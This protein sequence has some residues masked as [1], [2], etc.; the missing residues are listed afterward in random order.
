MNDTI[1]FLKPI[2]QER[3]WGGNRLS[4]IFNYNLTSDKIGECWGISAH[5]NGDCEITNP[6]YSGYTL[7][8]LF[9][10]RKDLFN[11]DKSKEFPLLI[12]ILDAN[13]SLSVQVHPDDEYALKYENDLGKNECWY[14]LDA[15]EDAFVIYGHIAKTEVEFRLMIEQGKWDDLLIKKHVKKGDFINV[16]AGTIHALGAGLLILETQQS[17]D[18]T[19]RLYDYDRTDDKGNKRQ[20]HI[21]ESIR[22]STIPHVEKQVHFDVHTMGDN[23][24][25]KLVK[26]EFFIVEKWDIKTSVT[27]NHNLYRL[28]SVI[29]GTG[30]INGLKIIKGDHFIITSLL[31]EFTLEGDFSLITSTV[32]SIK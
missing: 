20:L 2:F 21:E 13:T 28:C 22:V 16:P 10:E 23:T 3:I 6:E 30:K 26:N 5:K 8:K 18:T 1:V 31:N 15:N 7:S 4:K 11:N 29:D 14:V 19:Y 17:S 24:F 9:E 27:L 25:T 32:G 12:K